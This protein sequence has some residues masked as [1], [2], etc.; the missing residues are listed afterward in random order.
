MPARL[1]LALRL[2]HGEAI[3]LGIAQMTSAVMATCDHGVVAK[4]K[5]VRSLRPA[6]STLSHFG[7]SHF[8]DSCIGA[9]RS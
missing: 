5:R 3:A 9:H 8:V 1:G 4:I 7:S 2:H 6:T